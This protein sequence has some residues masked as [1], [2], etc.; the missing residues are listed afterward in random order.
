M[1]LTLKCFALGHEKQKV[2]YRHKRQISLWGNTVMGSRIKIV[3]K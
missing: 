3:P 1:C 2:L